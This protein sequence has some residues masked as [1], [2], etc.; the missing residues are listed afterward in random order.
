MFFELTD[1]QQMIVDTVRNFTEKELFPHEAM[2]EQGAAEER[3]AAEQSLPAMI[4]ERFGRRPPTRGLTGGSSFS[5]RATPLSPFS[6]TILTQAKA[7][8]LVFLKSDAGNLQNLL[9]K[10]ADIIEAANHPL[11]EIAVIGQRLAEKQTVLCRVVPDDIG[12]CA[13]NIGGQFEGN[14]HDVLFDY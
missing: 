6:A 1:E 14:C 5:T 4:P 10:L 2:V 8:I 13:A 9:Q 12:E 7:G 11:D 3:L